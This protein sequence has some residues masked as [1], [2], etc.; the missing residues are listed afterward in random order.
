MPGAPPDS[1]TSRLP[2]TAR[3]LAGAAAAAIAVILAGC[4]SHTHVAQTS[5]P[6]T[7]AASPMTVPV[8]TTAPPTTVAGQLPT[9]PDCGAGAYKPATLLIKCGIATEMATDVHWTSWDANGAEGQGTVHLTVNGH[10]VTAPAHLILSDVVTGAEGPQFSVLEIQWIGTSPTGSPS[11]RVA[12]V[13]QPGS[14][15]K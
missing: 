3:L 10:P 9:V 6:S 12:L 4:S 11:Q 1:R 5:S 7:T 13:V 2:G 8:A 15:S 14:S